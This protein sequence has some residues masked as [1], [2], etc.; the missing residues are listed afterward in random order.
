MSGFAAAMGEAGLPVIGDLVDI[1]CAFGT[2]F[3]G[4]SA[5][6]TSGAETTGST[7]GAATGDSTRP[8][9]VITVPAAITS[10]AAIALVHL[11]VIQRRGVFLAP[12]AGSIPFEAPRCARGKLS[13]TDT[14]RDDAATRPRASATIAPHDAHDAACA[15]TRAASSG[16]SSPSIQA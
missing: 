5:G 11:A 9:T 12:N 16:G 4:L 15:S 3:G 1:A 13:S 10:V 8:R 6:L 14:I 2:A 7:F